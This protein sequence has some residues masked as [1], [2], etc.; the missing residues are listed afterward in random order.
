MDVLPHEAAFVRQ[1]KA[2]IN[3][4]KT[5]AN[6]LGPS[7]DLIEVFLE[8]GPRPETLMAPPAVAFCQISLAAISTLIF[9]ISPQDRT[10]VAQRR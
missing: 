1:P 8:L 9:A 4:R 3:S 7:S 10:G 2:D 6:D 5:L